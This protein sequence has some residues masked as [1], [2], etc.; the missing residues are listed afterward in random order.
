M[1]VRLQ[2]AF[3]FA[4]CD[5]PKH[6]QFEPGMEVNEPAVIVSKI[7]IRRP[8]DEVRLIIYAAGSKCRPLDVKPL[9]QD[10]RY[11]SRCNF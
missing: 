1:D 8:S 10:R 9:E 6:F 3:A 4:A 11:V 5:Q 7:K 2:R